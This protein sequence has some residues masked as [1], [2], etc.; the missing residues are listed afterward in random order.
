M[1]IVAT[2]ES[3]QTGSGQS[4][5][6]ERGLAI[7]SAFK[8]ATPELGISELARVLGRVAMARIVEQLSR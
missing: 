8:P 7:L 2:R 3:A 6:L 5:S 1:R 4:Q